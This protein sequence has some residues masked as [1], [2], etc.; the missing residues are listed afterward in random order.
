MNAFDNICDGI[1]VIP[2]EQFNDD[3]M[4]KQMLNAVGASHIVGL[5]QNQQQLAFYHLLNQGDRIP[6]K[7]VSATI[8][9]LY[10]RL[11]I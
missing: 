11:Y 7:L 8:I 1:R 3:G 10:G 6:R 9:C 4:Y 2:A 5:T